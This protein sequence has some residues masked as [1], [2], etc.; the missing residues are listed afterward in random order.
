MGKVPIRVQAHLEPGGTGSVGSVKINGIPVQATHIAVS[1]G[2][3]EPPEVELTFYADEVDMEVKT[4][5][6]E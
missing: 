2:V 3:G 4:L 6:E 1:G 5:P